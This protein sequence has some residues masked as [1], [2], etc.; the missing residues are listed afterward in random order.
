MKPLIIIKLKFNS[1]A[2]NDLEQ[3]YEKKYYYYY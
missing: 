3:I 1:S 2:K